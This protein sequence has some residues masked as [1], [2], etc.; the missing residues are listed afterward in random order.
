MAVAH[1][2][3]AADVVGV[4]LSVGGL[5]RAQALLSGVRGIHLIQGDLT[6]PPLR[7]GTFD[8]VYSIGVIHHLAHPQVGFRTLE[9]M[10][11]P[12]GRLWVWVYGLEGMS[13]AYRL[14]HLVWLRRLTRS[15]SLE[16]KFRLCRLLALAFSCSYLFPLRL[17]RRLFPA[18]V[19]HRLPFTELKDASLEDTIYAF[20][21]RLQ[22]PYAHY[23]RK[24]ELEACL[25]GLDRVSVQSPN[26][27]GWVVKG[28]QARRG[29]NR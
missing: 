23:L 10:L 11:S 28:Q 15:W 16:A 24:A 12:E 2:N 26:K 4:D 19:A 21:D 5:Q 17:L 25:T 27:R 22:P 6:H 3:G 13:L 1:E 14:S 18:A 9:S 7:P 29:N 8:V 20:F